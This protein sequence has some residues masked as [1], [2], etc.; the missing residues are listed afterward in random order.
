MFLYFRICVLFTWILLETAVSHDGHVTGESTWWGW[1]WCWLN[2]SGA[3]GV[4]KLHTGVFLLPAGHEGLHAS[5]LE[6]LHILA[7]GGGAA[8]WGT[9]YGGNDCSNVC[10]ALTG[11]RPV[12]CVLLICPTIICSCFCFIKFCSAESSEF[13]DHICRDCW[14]RHGA[15]SGDGCAAIFQSL[16][17]IQGFS[18]WSRVSWASLSATNITWVSP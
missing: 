7:V 9:F 6:F 18:C 3:T 12:T 5:V 15:S 14:C 1:W 4:D 10:P 17:G 11:R 16:V 13:G 2:L 8:V